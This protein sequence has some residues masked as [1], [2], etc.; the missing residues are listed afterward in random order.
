M[1]PIMFQTMMTPGN[2]RRNGNEN[3][4]SIIIHHFYGACNEKRT[5]AWL[6]FDHNRFFHYV[7]VYR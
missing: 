1:S 7:K 6:Y 4:H 2:E 5:L 3:I